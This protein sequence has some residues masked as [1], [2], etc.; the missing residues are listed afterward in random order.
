MICHYAQTAIALDNYL[1]RRTAIR[2][3][4]FYEDLSIVERDRAAA[5]FAEGSNPDELD[6]PPGAQVLVCSE[7]GSEGRNFQFSHHLILFDLPASPD[8]LEQRIGRLDRIG[9]RHE[10]HIHIPYLMDSAQ[11]VLFRWLHEGIEAFTHSCPAGY[12]IYQQFA[13]QIRQLMQTRPIEQCALENLIKQTAAYSK[14]TIDR[15]R[16][17]RD[18]LLE[19]NSCNKQ[20]ADE[21]IE[22]ILKEDRQQAL[23]DY[24]ELVF[25]Q[26]GVEFDYHSEHSYVLKPGGHMHEHFPRLKRQRQYSDI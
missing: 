15:L 18:R 5:Y 2:S 22:R 19:L 12:Q 9:Q 17:G 26:F 20:Q 3:A 1:N 24:M 10:I 25:D 7:I 6:H 13:E 14:A 21:L 16:A 23:I 8:L 4:C 11:E